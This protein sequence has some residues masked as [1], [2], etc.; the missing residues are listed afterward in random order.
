MIIVAAEEIIAPQQ[1]CKMLNKN[2]LNKIFKHRIDFKL[3]MAELA[4]KIAT[5]FQMQRLLCS[6]FQIATV[7]L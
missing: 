5:I 3:D 1:R 7:K 6:T 4:L 2:K